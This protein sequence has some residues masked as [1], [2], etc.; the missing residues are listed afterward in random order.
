MLYSILSQIHFYLKH[1][2]WL[3]CYVDRDLDEIGK[4]RI[5]HGSDWY[6]KQFLAWLADLTFPKYQK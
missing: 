5:I 4:I 6:L 1:P 2:L 3:L